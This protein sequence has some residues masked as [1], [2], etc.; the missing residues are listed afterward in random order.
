VLHQS[1]LSKPPAAESRCWHRLAPPPPPRIQVNGAEDAAGKR[2]FNLTMPQRVFAVNRRAWRAC[3]G[4][5]ITEGGC[6]H[7]PHHVPGFI[8]SPTER[9]RVT[10]L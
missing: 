8:E 6:V 9:S 2:A 4:G 10:L 7:A 1:A 3:G 5:G